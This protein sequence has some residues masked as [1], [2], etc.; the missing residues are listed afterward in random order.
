MQEIIEPKLNDT[1]CDFCPGRSNTNQ[2]FTLQQIF[3]KSWE[4]AKDVCHASSTLRKHTTGFL[5]K[6][7]GGCCWSTVL[8]VTCYCL[9]SHCIPVQKFVSMSGEF[10]TVHHWCCTPT[11]VCAVTTSFISL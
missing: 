5:V 9:S 6:N 8:M 7:F 3:D 2:I 4:Y 11:R 1:Q 10:T